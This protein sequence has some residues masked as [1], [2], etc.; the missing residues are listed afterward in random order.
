[1]ADAA[2]V[3]EVMREAARARWGSTR[4]SRLAGEL[5]TRARELP[6]GQREALRLALADAEEA[7][8]HE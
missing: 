7:G 3:S 6:V 5:V 4:V 2:Q 8:S 1:M